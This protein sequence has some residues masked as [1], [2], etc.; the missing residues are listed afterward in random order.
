MTDEYYSRLLAAVRGNRK[1]KN[2]KEFK[3]DE[4]YVEFFDGYSKWV[5]WDDLFNTKNTIK[6]HIK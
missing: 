1:I 6:K 4:V 2:I 5:C 3:N